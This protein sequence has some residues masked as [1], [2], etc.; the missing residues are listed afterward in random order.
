MEA[1]N[2]PRFGPAHLG[3]LAVQPL[4]AWLLATLARR[5][6]PA[7]K[8]ILWGL[9]LSLFATEIGWFLALLL[10]YRVGWKWMLPLQLSDAAILLTVLML[11][12][13][14]QRLFDVVF[15]WGLTAVPLAMLMPDLLEPFPD[16]YTIV[17]FVVHGLVVVILL[18][19]VW[20]GEFKPSPHSARNSFLTLNLFML[21]VLGVNFALG[22][23]Y[24]YLMRKPEQPSLLDY[25]GP[26]PVYILTGELVAI[27]L[28]WLV[29]IAFRP[30]HEASPHS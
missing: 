17:F 28:F 10:H 1:T 9:G 25:F 14:S 7:R 13:R 20:S 19:L 2:F 8:P 16:P 3:V 26:W 11:V 22:T 15:Y 12:L 6:P 4:L 5:Y 23:N 21:A 27:G 24:M 29:W 30:T 18:Y